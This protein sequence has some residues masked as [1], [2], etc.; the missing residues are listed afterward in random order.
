MQD[1]IFVVTLKF[2]DYSFVP[3]SPDQQHKQN[4]PESLRQLKPI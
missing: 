4:W 1:K 2:E 3:L